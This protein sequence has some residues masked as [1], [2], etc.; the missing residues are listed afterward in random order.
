MQPRIYLAESV[1]LPLIWRAISQ[2]LGFLNE[3]ANAGGAVT[4]GSF[5]L[6]RDEVISGFTTLLLQH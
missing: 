2:H 6:P 3:Q 1:L 4:F 5:E